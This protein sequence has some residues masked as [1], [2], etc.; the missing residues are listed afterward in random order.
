MNTAQ[1]L[2]D[3][4]DAIR[5]VR[6]TGGAAEVPAQP[7]ELPPPA[8]A[9]RA[10]PIAIIGLSGSFPQAASVDAFWRALDHDQPV[11]EEIPQVRF[12]WKL[13]SDSA[14]AIRS[15]WGGFIPD[16]A[17]FDPAFFDIPPGEAALTDPRL[18]L[19]L[20][21]AYQTLVDAGHAPRSMRRS[22]TGVFVAMQDNEYRI[23]SGSVPRAASE[24][25]NPPQARSCSAPT[26][27]WPARSTNAAS[28][29]A[30]AMP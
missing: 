7:Q 26:S 12:N 29:L 8:S 21:S 25:R 27:S 10:E 4:E 24:R 1:E 11:I 3:I 30:P 14:H 19:L 18:R 22:R 5:K 28:R 9:A 23:G 20:M 17:G 16:I 13:L 15:P 2:K 6:S